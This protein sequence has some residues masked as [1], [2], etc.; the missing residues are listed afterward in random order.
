MTEVPFQLAGRTLIVGPS[1]A[2][3]TRLTARA[4]EAWIDRHGTDGVVVLETAPAPNAVFVND[5]TIPL[6]HESVGAKQLT[7]YCDAAACTVF[8]AL[9][10]DELGTD[11]SVSRE[12]RTALSELRPWADRTVGLN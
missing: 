2:G 3:K 11:D 8:N 12:E 10:S 5:A 9:D 7:G 1:Q 6:Q 4:L